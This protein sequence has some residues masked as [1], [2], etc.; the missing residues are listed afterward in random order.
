M[1]ENQSKYYVKILCK[2]LLY[3]YSSLQ[4]RER[5][6]VQGAF[7]WEIRGSVGCASHPPSTSPPPTSPTTK[8]EKK[9]GPIMVHFSVVHTVDSTEQRERR[10]E[11]NGPARVHF[12]VV[13]V[14]A[15]FPAPFLELYIQL[16]SKLLVHSTWPTFFLFV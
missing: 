9:K 16:V 8:R 4:K 2:I 3:V 12:A 1:I 10:G 14:R 13:P 5:T 11:T 6:F 15:Q 7:I